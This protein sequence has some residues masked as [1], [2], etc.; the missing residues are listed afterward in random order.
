MTSYI[1]AQHHVLSSLQTNLENWHLKWNLIKKVWA[2]QTF[3][4]GPACSLFGIR[5]LSDVSH[6]LHT[7]FK[8]RSRVLLPCLIEQ[9]NKIWT[10]CSQRLQKFISCKH[11]TPKTKGSFDTLSFL[12]TFYQFF[13]WTDTI[14]KDP[15]QLFKV[16]FQYSQY[17]Q[18]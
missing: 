15:E 18:Q 11:K 8:Q 14:H 6:L 10:Y 4:P 7:L 2:L 1:T 5:F 9:D 12:Y 16:R 17:G 13:H 3:L